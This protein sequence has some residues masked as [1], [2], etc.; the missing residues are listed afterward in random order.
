MPTRSTCSP[1]LAPR[2]RRDW[3]LTPHPGEAGRLLGVGAAEVQKD[4][5]GALAALL[6]R[7]GGTVVLKGAGTLVGAAGR[8]PGLCERGNPGMATAGTGDVLTGAIAGILAQCQDAWAAARVGVLVHAM[9]GDAAARGGRTRRAGER[10]GARAPQQRQS[11]RRARRVR[12]HTPTAAD[13]EALGGRL[14][15]SRP[16]DRLACAV[17][18]LQG[19]LGSGKTTLARGFLQALRRHRPGPQPDLYAASSSTPAAGI[20]LVHAD[21][22]R[23]RD[24]AELESLGLR[25]WAA[26]GHLWLVE[27]PEK[28]G[29]KAAAAG[30]RAHA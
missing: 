25:E 26:P 15:R 17:V 10:S 20:T 18:Y 23:L 22:Y 9:A 16:A 5:L 30:P 1:R 14:A 3:I 29:G 4:R 2:R 19:E 6:E 24:P 11:V 27:W 21:L 13:T 12:I 8:T 28:G 7:F